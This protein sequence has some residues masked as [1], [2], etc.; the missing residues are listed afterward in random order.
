VLSSSTIPEQQLNDLGNN[1]IRTQLA[2]VQGAALPYPYGGKTRQIQV[3]LNPQAMQTYGISAQGINAAIGAQNLIIPA[4][5]QKIG[6]YEYIVKLNWS[7]LKVEDLNDVPVKAIPGR[8][9]YIR[10][11]GLGDG[12]E[13]NAPLGRAVIG[14]L[15]FATVSTLLFVPSVFYLIH[16]RRLK[17][18]Q[19]KEHA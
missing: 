2:T 14:G 4:G 6:Q 10:D 5:T 11:V 9:L 7:P 17:A 1:F 12:G 18:K 16:H 19:R 15:S 8:V 13:Q 3:D